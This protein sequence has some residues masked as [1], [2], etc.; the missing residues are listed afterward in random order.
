[1]IGAFVIVFLLV[2]ITLG[3]MGILMKGETGET[4]TL[5]ILTVLNCIGILALCL[6]CFCCLKRS[7]SES[8]NCKKIT[9]YHIKLLSLYLFA[10]GYLFHCG[11]YAWKHSSSIP[12]NDLGLCYNILTII[13]IFLLLAY[14]SMCQNTEQDESVENNLFKTVVFVSM[15]CCWVDAFLSE[16]NNLFHNK[17]GSDT[18]N[19]QNLT[20]AEEA[21]RYTD[22]LFTPAMIEFY[23]MTIN[24]L[25]TKVGISSDN[26][27]KTQTNIVCTLF[28]FVCQFIIFLGVFALFAFTCTVL[29]SVSNDN[30]NDFLIYI[31]FQLLIKCIFF[32]IIC[33]IIFSIPWSSVDIN[34]SFAVLFVSCIGNALYHT[35]YLLAYIST[36]I[37]KNT[38]TSGVSIAENIIS[39]LIAGLQTLFILMMDNHKETSISKCINCRSCVK[40]IFVYYACSLLGM[41]NLGLWLSDSVGEFWYLEFSLPLCQAYGH[42]FCLLIQKTLLPVTIFF[43]F[44]T[45]VEFL[46]LYW[47]HYCHLQYVNNTQSNE[48]QE[49]NPQEELS[50]VPDADLDLQDNE[51]FYSIETV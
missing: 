51:L 38:I 44:H 34:A 33:V 37:P 46:K 12:K 26:G 30:L 48:I 10:L 4:L 22:P 47:D 36:E 6:R 21:T 15:I 18:Q 20:R 19:A 42:Q 17:D 23:F 13:Y 39:L 31:F 2:L 1:M 3:R 9:F 16:A 24:I 50:P 28:R 49:N 7:P 11:L 35:L 41:I 45:G 14:F 25:Y 27:S 5:I 40:D 43:R 29:I 8:G 32:I